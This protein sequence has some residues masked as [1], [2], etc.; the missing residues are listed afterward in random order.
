[1]V[2]LKSGDLIY[3]VNKDSEGLFL[4]IDGPGYANVT[5]DMEQMKALYKL[6]AKLYGKEPI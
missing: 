4:D 2:Q 3:T 5:L 1:M 6:L